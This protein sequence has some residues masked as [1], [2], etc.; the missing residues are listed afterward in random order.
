VFHALEALTA[1]PELE[2]HA[3]AL[4]WRGRGELATLLPNG[5]R[6]VRRPM[7][8]RPLRMAWQHLD[9]PV[10]ERWT[11]KIDVVHGTNFVVPPSR[12]AA[13]VV[14]VHD[15]TPVRYPELCTRATLAYPDLIRRAI[16]R[17]AWVHTP[18][19]FVAH[20]VVDRL[21][22]DPE[23]VVAVASGVPP[24]VAADPSAGRRLAG[25][26]RYIL[27]VGTIEPR[28]DH[29]ALVR[30]F[31][32]V[33]DRHADVHLVVAG[34][35]GWAID[36]FG[37]EVQRARHRDRVVRLGYVD[38]VGRSAL[39]RGATVFA[40]PSRYE[41]FGFP[42]LEAMEAGLPVVATAVGSLPEVLGDAALLVPPDDDE[43]LAHGLELV[44]SDDA[45]QTR[46]MKAGRNQVAAYSWKACAE[47][48]T[49]VYQRA[50]RSSS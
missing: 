45:L 40:F 33:A 47:G 29:A 11:G 18:S 3:F 44:L 23:R 14:T 35:D 6:R 27:T 31:D 46:L 20:E 1:H 9:A 41:G 24:V 25:A 48:L 19:A 43:A 42:P 39:L 13:R 7:S 34:V 30:A 26:D 4:T 2:L 15:L 21:G 8:A 10:I 22:A 36:T 5:V 38:E 28:K 37:A 50:A 12:R 17:G 16:A 32:R 49:D